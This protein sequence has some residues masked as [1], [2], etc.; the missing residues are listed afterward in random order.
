MATMEEIKEEM[1]EAQKL[2][3]KRLVKD[4]KV[5]SIRDFMDEFINPYLPED[6]KIRPKVHGLREP[7]TDYDAPIGVIMHF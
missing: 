2:V 6:Q 3:D 4:Y 7:T 5:A 1:K